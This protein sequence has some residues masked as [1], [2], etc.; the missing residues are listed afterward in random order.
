MT[1]GAQVTGIFNIADRVY[2]QLN[3]TRLGNLSGKLNAAEL[4]KL[5]N[6]PAA[7][8]VYDARSGHIN[9]IQ[10]VDEKFFAFQY[11]IMK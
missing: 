9:V 2:A 4:Q 11:Q 1:K 8:C 10:S 3:D 6:N 7:V 5:A